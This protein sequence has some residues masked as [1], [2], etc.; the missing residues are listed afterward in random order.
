MLLSVSVQIWAPEMMNEAN[1]W[2][3]MI[4]GWPEQRMPAGDTF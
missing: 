3:M 2:M 1:R 4:Y